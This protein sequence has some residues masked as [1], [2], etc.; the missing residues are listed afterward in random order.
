M[1]PPIILGGLIMP[2]VKY[3]FYRG[4]TSG[5][6][7]TPLRDGQILFDKERQRIALDAMVN[8]VLTRIIMTEKD[9]FNGTSAQWNALTDAQKEMFTYVN[10]FDDY[11][12]ST[13]FQGATA[14]TDGEMG[15]VPKPIAGDQ[16]KVIKGDGTWGT[17]PN[18]SWT[19][20]SA[21]EMATFHI[22]KGS[23]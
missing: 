20:N 5:I 15:F 13:V 6:D 9:T 12:E 11:V 23:F 17:L 14:S 7:A 19:Y 3:S 10:L 1:S 2:D 4:D 18:V 16:N 21:N 22:D 8:G